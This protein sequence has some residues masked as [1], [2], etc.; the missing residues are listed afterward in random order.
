MSKH[1]CQCAFCPE[2][3]AVEDEDI[4]IG[5]GWTPSFFIGDVEIDQM[6]CLWCR[7]HLEAGQDYNFHISHSFSGNVYRYDFVLPDHVDEFRFLSK[8]PQEEIDY[9]ASLHPGCDVVFFL[10]RVDYQKEEVFK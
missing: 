9:L 2:K 6:V 5:L 1:I 8:P 10:E 3:I 4:A 7:G